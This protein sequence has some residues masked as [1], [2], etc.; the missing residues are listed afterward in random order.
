M[1]ARRS[2]EYLRS[3]VQR[4]VEFRDLFLQFRDLHHV[5]SVWETRGLATPMVPRDDADPRQL[6]FLRSKVSQAA[7]G[8]ETAVNMTGM[9]MSVE[10]QSH[11]VNPVSTWWSV[12]EPKAVVYPHHVLDVCDQAIGR[13]DSMAEFAEFDQPPT[14]G[15]E[16]MHPLVWD[17]A[18]KPWEKGFYSYAVERAHLAL[19]NRACSHH[20]TNETGVAVWA[21]LFNEKPKSGFQ[22]LGWPGDPASNDV[23]NMNDG[24]REYSRALQRLIRNALAHPTGELDRQDALERLGAISLLA[25]WMDRCDSIDSAPDGSE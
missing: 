13:L 15:V 17:A 8:A 3:L 18:K 25:R 14:V 4:V 22:R 19:Y 11:P 10:G 20:S 5:Y 7:G 16:A 2:P 21:S 6:E 23:K 9:L 12:L 1:E 24:L